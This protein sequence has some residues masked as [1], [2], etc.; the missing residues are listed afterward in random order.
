M[1]RLIFL[2]SYSRLSVFVFFQKYTD[3]CSY[4]TNYTK[5]K[6]VRSVQSSF[7]SNFT[8]EVYFSN[9]CCM[10]TSTLWK[11]YE[12][13]SRQTLLLLQQVLVKYK[14]THCIT[15]PFML[16]SSFWV[17]K[18]VIIF[19]GTEY[20]WQKLQVS[21]LKCGQAESAVVIMSPAFFIEELLEIV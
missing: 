18:E 17:W 3:C 5:L 9:F 13:I 15:S 19:W 16:I 11:C 2:I 1:Q 8:L 7:R 20:C 4:D 12:I 10:C 14:R 21:S 6:I